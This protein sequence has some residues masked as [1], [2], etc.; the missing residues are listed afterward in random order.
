MVGLAQDLDD[1]EPELEAGLEKSQ[2]VSSESV[3]FRIDLHCV[4]SLD[5]K[6]FMRMPCL[7]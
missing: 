7:A 3:S 6:Q 4:Y 1:P 2:A 5:A